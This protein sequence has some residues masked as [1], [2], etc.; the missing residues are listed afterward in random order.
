MSN[1]VM[2]SGMM[3]KDILKPSGWACPESME[4]KTFAQST[5]GS[6]E[7]EDNKAVTITE[8]GTLVIEPSAGKDAMSKVTATV[9][10]SATA[11]IEA[12]KNVSI[13][14]NGTTEIT[15]SQGYDGLGKATVTV[16]VPSD[17]KEEQTKSVTVTENG[18]TTVTPDSGKVLSSVSI[19]TS[20]AP[21]KAD[22]YFMWF[23]ASQ[24]STVSWQ[25]FGL[26]DSTDFEAYLTGQRMPL[27]IYIKGKSSLDDFTVG[28]TLTIYRCG[29]PS[30]S[31]ECTV[32]A[33]SATE[34]TFSYTLNGSATTLT[35]NRSS[36]FATGMLST[37]ARYE[38]ITYLPSW[39]RITIN[40][41]GLNAQEVT[42]DGIQIVN[43]DVP[44][45][46]TAPT[47]MAFKAFSPVVDTAVS[48]AISQGAG[49]YVMF[50]ASASTEDVTSLS[51]ATL[52]QDIIDGNVT[53][54]TVQQSG[55]SMSS[56]Q[57][58]FNVAC[59]GSGYPYTFTFTPTAVGSSFTN[60]VVIGRMM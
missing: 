25:G 54:I 57:C 12:N 2:T 21:L 29:Y 18:T 55:P 22:K 20:V 37:F 32:S 39:H 46:V 33:K 35:F 38:G 3:M 24:S 19:T 56:Y 9:N 47:K 1:N 5:A 50:G 13:I 10:V 58:T 36:T 7:L 42:S 44:A 6:A 48:W 14:A 26:D 53:S 59:S 17:A 23:Y 15:P 27:G 8:N 41:N 28:E 30:Q 40:T 4:N 49:G 51:Q 16:N 31:K 60:K 34:V 11:N 45:S 52:I 43:V